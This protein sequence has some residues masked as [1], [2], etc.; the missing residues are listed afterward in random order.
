MHSVSQYIESM[1]YNSVLCWFSDI[2]TATLI[3][4]GF[5]ASRVPGAYNSALSC[6]WRSKHHDSTGAN[7]VNVLKCRCR[8]SHGD[9]GCTCAVFSHCFN[10][11]PQK[12]PCQPNLLECSRLGTRFQV[13]ILYA[14][15]LLARVSQVETLCPHRV[16]FALLREIYSAWAYLNPTY[17]VGTPAVSCLP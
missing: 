8:D 4:K 15:T 13:P 7:L 14:L 17:L 10:A 3:R 11:I 16:S 6:R 9:Y 5:L 12:S 1:G 2:P